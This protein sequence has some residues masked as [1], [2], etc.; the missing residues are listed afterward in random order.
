MA[1]Y[2]SHTVQTMG[3]MDQ[4]LHKFHDNVQVLSEF[5]ETKKHC[6]EAQEASRELVAGQLKVR[7]ARLEEYV[8][9][10]ATQRNRL[11][12]EDR[13][14]RAQVIQGV[15]SQAEFIFPKMHLR[16]YDSSQIKDFGSLPQ[17]SPEMTEAL[18]KLLTDAYR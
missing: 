7:Q 9:L 8:E 14:E 18:H 13:Q 4:Y 6:Q 16:S 2:H 5:R 1:Q 17:Y 3:Y 10:S 12:V 15:L 11:A